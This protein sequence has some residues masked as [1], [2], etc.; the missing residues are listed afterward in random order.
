MPLRRDVEEAAASL[1]K[2]DAIDYINRT[3]NA[4]LQSDRLTILITGGSQGAESIN[5]SVPEAIVSLAESGRNNLQVL[6]F[7]GKGKQLK[8]AAAYGNS[9]IPKLV[10]ESTDKM[11]YFLAASDI[12]FSRSG[13]STVAELSLFGKAAVLVP[14]PTSAEGHQIDNAKYFCGSGAGVLLENKNLSTESIAEILH[15]SDELWLE[16]RKKSAKLGRAQAAEA[17]LAAIE[18]YL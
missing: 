17:L 18:E 13:G 6:H 15:D 2:S 12:V 8:A 14:L 3:F 11:A 16:R 9:D 5:L 4:E 1:N 7:A 10:I